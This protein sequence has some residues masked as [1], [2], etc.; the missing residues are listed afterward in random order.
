MLSDTTVFVAF[1]MDGW[2][3]CMDEKKWP[4]KILNFE[5]NGSFPRNCPKKRWFDNYRCDLDKLWV[6]TSLTLD[7]IKW[8]NAIKPSSYVAESN[9]RCWGK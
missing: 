6:S 1:V 5:V 2:M 3:K 9:P 4:N 7:R 8:R